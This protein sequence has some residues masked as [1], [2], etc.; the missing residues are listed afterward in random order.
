MVFDDFYKWT[1]ISS[2]KHPLKGQCS[3]LCFRDRGFSPL[4]QTWEMTLP[5]KEHIVV[6]IFQDTW[7]S[8]KV[9]ALHSDFCLSTPSNYVGRT[10]PTNIP[11]RLPLALHT[12]TNG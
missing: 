9:V 6:C 3:V 2:S 8:Q 5:S 4:G 1:K 10:Y 12:K 7:K 11:R